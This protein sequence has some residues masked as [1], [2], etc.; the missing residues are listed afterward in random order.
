[1]RFSGATVH[2]VEEA[3]DTGPVLAQRAVPVLPDDT[4]GSLAARVLVQVNC[5]I[6]AEP[7][8]GSGQGRGTVPFATHA[9]VARPHC[10]VP[11]LPDDMLAGTR[12]GAGEP[13]RAT[14]AIGSGAQITSSVWFAKARL[15]LPYPTFSQHM[16]EVT[17]TPS[18][19]TQPL[20]WPHN[21]VRFGVGGLCWWGVPVLNALRMQC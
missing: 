5:Q 17:A 2:F 14:S 16:S 9:D 1:M 20:L 4:P 18:I 19:H 21:L 12:A 11:V 3:Y 15:T 13:E 6:H 8:A 10:K 7:A